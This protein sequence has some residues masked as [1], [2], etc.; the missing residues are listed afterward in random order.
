MDFFTVVLRPS[1]NY[2]VALCLENGVVGQGTTKE[3]AVTKL[4]E[5][6]ESLEEIFK[7][8]T[9]VYRAPISIKELHEFLA[10][11]GKEPTEEA[12]ELRAVHA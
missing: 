1:G 3:E 10:L 4:K 7:T 9:E 2:W 11:E 6:L 12:Y 5:A 8:E